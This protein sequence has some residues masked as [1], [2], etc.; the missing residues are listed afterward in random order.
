MSPELRALLDRYQGVVT[1]AEAG[2]VVPPWVFAT[3]RRAGDLRRLLPGVYADAALADSTTTRREAALRYLDGRG[4]LSH[5]TALEVWG[6]WDCQPSDHIHVTVPVDVRLRP[7]RIVMV[8]R[9][10]GF[11]NGPPHMVAR[12]GVPVT[13]LEQTLVD[14]WPLMPEADRYKP[15][16]RAVNDRLTTA[17]RLA[18]ALEDTPRLSDR[19]ACRGLLARLASGCRSALEIWGHDHV[20]TGSDL[21]PLQRQVRVQVGGRTLYLDVYAE[22]ERVDFEL[23]GAASHGSPAQREVDLRRDAL[24]ATA[25]ILVVRFSHQRLRLDTAAVRREIRAILEAR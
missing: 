22:A 16:I 7:G 3:A 5:T 17:E 6:L 19:A 21:P 14:A 24:L 10:A 15:M 25:G 8:H 4:A 9:R 2:Q 13:R 20:F 23:D 11:E 18:G 12:D 1:R